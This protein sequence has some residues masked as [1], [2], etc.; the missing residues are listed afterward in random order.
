MILQ[1]DLESQESA[2]STEALDELKALLRFVSDELKLGSELAIVVADPLSERLSLNHIVG[3][4]G[5]S[6]GKAL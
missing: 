4:L 6:I 5:F 1:F 2:D 3:Y